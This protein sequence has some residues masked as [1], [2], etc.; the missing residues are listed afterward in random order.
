MDSNQNDSSPLHQYVHILTSINLLAA[1]ALLYF[2]FY[3]TGRPPNWLLYGLFSS[4]VLQFLS[5][6]YLL[7]TRQ[8]GTAAY[9]LLFTPVSFF[10]GVFLPVLAGAAWGRPLRVNNLQTHADLTPGSDWTSGD[11]PKVDD[12]DIPTRRALQALWLHDA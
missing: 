11:Q 2:I 4:L 12:L 6:L 10:V 8:K 3:R 9:A 1:L 7:T 5:S